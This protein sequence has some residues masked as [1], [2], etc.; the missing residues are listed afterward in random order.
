VTASLGIKNTLR[1]IDSRNV[2]AR[3]E[4][5]D[6][7]RKDEY[8]IYS[9]HWDH[10]GIG[11][12]VKGDKIYNGALDN[13]SGVASVLEIA[14]AFTQV[15]PAPKRSIL[16]LMVTAEEQGLLGS[17]YYATNPIYPLDKT[18]AN[19]NVDGVNQWGRTSDLTI[20]G[21]GASEL[22]DYIASDERWLRGQ[23]AEDGWLV[24]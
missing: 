11:T 12:P 9:A 19:I 16:F 8:V 4:G 14:R 23:F 3:L 7:A 5:S 6:P 21:L 13:A 24:K 10:F 18:L 2:V 15:Q 1:T 22:D 17:Q 20:I